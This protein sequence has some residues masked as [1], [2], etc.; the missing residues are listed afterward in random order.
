MIYIWRP[1]GRVVGSLID[2]FHRLSVHQLVHSGNHNSFSRLYTVEIRALASPVGEYTV[3]SRLLTLLSFYYPHIGFLVLAFT[4]YGT[5]RNIHKL[6]FQEGSYVR[7]SLILHV[8]PGFTSYRERLKAGSSIVI[9]TG[10][11]VPA[12]EIS[13]YS[14]SFALNT[15][16]G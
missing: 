16:S 3:T 11:P 8:N 13:R 5:E 4:E 14:S 1:Q 15:V 9:V 2:N 7:S 10:I 12:V 6:F